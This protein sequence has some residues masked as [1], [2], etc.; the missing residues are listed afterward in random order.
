MPVLGNGDIWE[1]A[2]AVRMMRE[3]GC[4]GVVVGRGCLGRPWLFGAFQRAFDGRPAVPDPGLAEVAEVM[5]R[6]AGLMAEWMGEDKGLREFRKHVSW[7]LKG[8]A[9]GGDDPPGARSGVHPRRARRAARH[10]RRHQPFPA[11][12]RG[13]AA[14]P[15]RVAAPGRAARGLARRPQ[16]GGQLDADAEL[17]VS[18]G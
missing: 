9:V 8:F 6:H 7:Y 18:G 12:R 11:G 13:R 4:D 14:R 3:T 10:P 17:A 1:A 16:A 15:A 2:D 5:R